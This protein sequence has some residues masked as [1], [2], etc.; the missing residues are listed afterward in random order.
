[1][2]SSGMGQTL[3][4]EGGLKFR[5]LNPAN[6]DIYPMNPFLE[7]AMR[8][9]HNQLPTQRKP[10]QLEELTYDVKKATE[11]SISESQKLTHFNSNL[12]LNPKPK[13]EQKRLEI[14][15]LY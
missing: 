15:G 6:T 13:Q 4:Y 5:N 8:L 9:T 7:S 11:L 10:F 3:F 1:M 14:R 2:H 12:R